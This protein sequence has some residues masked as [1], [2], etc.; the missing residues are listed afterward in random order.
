MKNLTESPEGGNRPRQEEVQCSVDD[1][2]NVR[3]SPG[4]GG[5]RADVAD[6]APGGKE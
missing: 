3:L 2:A 4:A 6:R 5:L 1:R